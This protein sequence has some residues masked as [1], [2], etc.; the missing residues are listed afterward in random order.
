MLTSHEVEVKC[1]HKIPLSTVEVPV[2]E[3]EYHIVQASCIKCNKIWKISIRNWENDKV[4]E[5]LDKYG[6]DE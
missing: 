1:N 5:L 3:R 2:Q 4:N 6:V